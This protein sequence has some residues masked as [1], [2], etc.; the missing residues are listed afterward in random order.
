MS[1]Y[2]M[3]VQQGTNL[4]VTLAMGKDSPAAIA[5]YNAAYAKQ[6][7]RYTAQDARIAAEKNIA[8]VRSDRML[9]DMHIQ[10]KQ[11]TVEAQIRTQ[12][13][14]AGA[15]GGSVE[16]TVYETESAEARRLA[17]N[18]KNEE[19]TTAGL[20]A[21]AGSAY[22]QAASIQEVAQP[23][24]GMMLLDSFSNFSKDDLADLGT[25]VRGAPSASQ[26]SSNFS[27]EGVPINFMNTGESYA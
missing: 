2:A 22:S 1:G 5:A 12:A 6:V 24:L 4:A 18:K 11:N 27:G 7:Q 10:L 9:Q 15:E 16:A 3:A 26:T 21:Q 13:A 20:A 23:S 8:S 25:M 19:N 17:D 14:W